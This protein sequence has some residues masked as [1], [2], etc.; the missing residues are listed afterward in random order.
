MIIN[1]IV[2]NYKY[3]IDHGNYHY[4]RTFDESLY[5]FIPYEIPEIFKSRLNNFS[6]V[7]EPDCVGFDKIKFETPVDLD[8]ILKQKWYVYILEISD[9]AR[10]FANFE[11]A[12]SFLINTDK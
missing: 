2:E 12:S 11:R 1:V 7:Y 8:I 3:Y 9:R 6:I 10:F 4:I 5:D